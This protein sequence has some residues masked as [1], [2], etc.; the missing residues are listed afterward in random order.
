[1]PKA[2]GVDCEHW[3]VSGFVQGFLPEDINGHQHRTGQHERASPRQGHQVA[4]E[5]DAR[6]HQSD[7]IDLALERDAIAVEVVANPGPKPRVLHQPMV[8]TR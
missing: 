1:M 3:N 7:G 8:E 6:P 5:Q 4:G 2:M